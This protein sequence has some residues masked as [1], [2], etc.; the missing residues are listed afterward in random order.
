MDNLTIWHINNQELEFDIT[1]AES[2]ERYEAVLENLRK[3]IPKTKPTGI[4]TSKFIRSYCKA[5]RNL[6]DS[7]F[8][9]G[10]SEKIFDGVPE[11]IRRYNA[12]YANFLGF[13]GMQTST[14][15]QEIDEIEKK[16]LPEKESKGGAKK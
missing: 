7:L 9:E 4:T 11:S 10:T 2:A 1:E 8:G 13:V 14:M 12:V 3:D 5:H 15:K 16:Y 6:Y